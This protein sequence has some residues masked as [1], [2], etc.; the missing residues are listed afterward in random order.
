[1]R[2]T[3]KTA[4]Q[5]KLIMQLKHRQMLNAIQDDL[6]KQFKKL[7]NDDNKSTQ[8]ELKDINEVRLPHVTQET[9]VYS[10]SI[11]P[12]VVNADEEYDAVTQ[13][14]EHATRK[15]NIIKLLK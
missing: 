8:W 5:I 10:K 6:E 7:P 15:E 3:D 11:D 2:A 9:L 12:A 1:M 4:D 14:F 13:A